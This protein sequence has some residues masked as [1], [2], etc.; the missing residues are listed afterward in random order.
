M[1]TAIMLVQSYPLAVDV[2][3]MM[4][5]MAEDAGEPSVADLMSGYAQANP[6]LDRE[7]LQMPS[8]DLLLEAAHWSIDYP[9]HSI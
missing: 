8:P 1:Q 5:C 2:V 4:N 7:A 3:Y 9:E 6:I